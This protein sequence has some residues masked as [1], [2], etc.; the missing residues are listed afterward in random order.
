MSIR[1]L[2]VDDEEAVRRLLKKELGRKGY[3]TDT[4]EN[5]DRACSKL[6][7]SSFD[8]ILLDIV[9]PGM[10]GM[11][12]L[13]KLKN[14]PAAPAIIV[15][16]GKATVDTAVSAM[17]AGASDYLTYKL[18]ELS[19][20]IN[21]AYE[22]RKLSLENQLLKK[23]LARR[24]SPDTFVGE[25]P[26]FREILT[27]ID[28][29][30]PTDSTVLISGE[31]GT[32]KELVAHSIWKK[33]GRNKKSFIALNCSTLSEHLMES[34]LFGHEK[35]A[36]TH[37]LKVK[38]GLVETANGGI[39]FLDEIAE[40]PVSLQAKLLRF[41]DSGDFRRVGGNKSLN[42]DVRVIA[43]TNKNL[44]E[45]MIRGKFREDLFYRLNVIN[46]EIPPLRDRK[47]DIKPLAEHFI[48]HYGRKISK[49]VNALDDDAAE[50]LFRYDWPGNVRE[51][52]NVIERAVILCESEVIT[53]DDLAIKGNALSAGSPEHRQ[54]REVERDYILTV[55]KET[56]GN[57]T[58]ASRL[59][60][61][62]RKTLYLKLKKYG[63]TQ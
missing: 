52:E 15:L 30:A 34:E 37:A 43:A 38:N 42:A 25:S 58:R 53:G 2:I 12:M 5:G 14:D 35:G 60:G 41:L 51:L 48:R 20:V 27:L 32:G 61:V 16:T 49:T 22:Q 40:I 62:D 57:Q 7:D 6:M 44:Q 13:K 28:K 9:M 24:E 33:S 45:E 59:L 10:N 1:I 21:R 47:Q 23:E 17:K 36:F 4:A 56:G 29:I 11:S 3:H 54:L 18:D 8:I 46:I 63:L 31:S 50:M 26:R 19:I 39:L 55:L